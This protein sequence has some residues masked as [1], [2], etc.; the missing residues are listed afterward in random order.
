M[1][2]DI[3]LLDAD[4]RE[5]AVQLLRLAKDSGIDLIVTETL[6]TLER[7]A[8]LYAKGRTAPGRIVTYARPGWSWHNHGR[9]FDVAILT[10]PGD[11]SP[12][13]VYDGPWSEVGAMGESLGLEWGGRWKHPDLPH[14]QHTSGLTLAALN[15]GGPR[16]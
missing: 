8:E 15:D 9:A 13:D 12:D 5:R 6:R 14:F 7:Q 10:W 3:L 16:G 11:P 1:S 4:V 2:R